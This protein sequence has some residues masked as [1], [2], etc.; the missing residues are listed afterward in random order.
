MKSSAR[1]EG[2]DERVGLQETDIVDNILL[3]VR[4]SERSREE[5]DCGSRYAS[6]REFIALL[7]ERARKLSDKKINRILLDP[8]RCC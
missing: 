3:W 6:S 1:S 7:Q 8:Y 4:E 5:M 2:D